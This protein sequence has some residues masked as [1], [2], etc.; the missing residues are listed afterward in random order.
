MLSD[1]EE[2][3][4]NLDIINKSFATILKPLDFE[5]ANV[6][7]RDTILLAPAGMGSLKALG[8]LY[9]SEGDFNKI[10][11]SKEDLENMSGFLARDKQAFEA[12]A[13]QDAIITLKHSIAMEEFNFGIQKLGVPLTL[14]SLGRN[15]VFEE[16]RKTQEKHIPYQPSGNCLLGNSEEVQTPKGL[17]YTGD[18]GLHLSYFIGNYKGG[19]NESFMYGVDP[20]TIF[21]DVDLTSAYTTAMAHLS[22]PNYSSG[23]LINPAELEK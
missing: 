1:F 18:V 2:M 7:V 12:Y 14:S 19:R 9:S 6:Y 21:Y 11:I 4:E 22:F 23:S 8:S 5:S 16:W 10:E 17:F 15:F 20:E 13:L 3:K